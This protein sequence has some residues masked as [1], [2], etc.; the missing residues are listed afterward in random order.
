[1]KKNQ[2]K[3]SKEAV[4][5]KDEDDFRIDMDD[6][7]FKE[8]FEDHDY[9]IDPNEP[10]FKK[11]KAMMKVLDERNKRQDDQRRR[12]SDKSDKERRRGEKSRKRKAEG[13]G[14]VNRLVEKIKRK[15]VKSA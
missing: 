13:G 6:D 1:M 9:A 3:K 2:S 11:T 10:E 14:D 5:E 15:Y 8:I 7:R 12:K 4:Q